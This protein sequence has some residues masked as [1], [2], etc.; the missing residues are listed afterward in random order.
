MN[1]LIIF[2]LFFVSNI[3]CAPK[4]DKQKQVVRDDGQS[5]QNPMG[6]QQGYVFQQD[7]QQQYY[8][9]Q[10]MPEDYQSYYPQQYTQA[11]SDQFQG[12]PIQNQFGTNSTI[13]DFSTYQPQPPI[14]EPTKVSGTKGLNL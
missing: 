13:F 1:I 6:Y 12:I 3:Q 4:K 2:L 10:Q 7:Y 14:Q 11:F 5:S 8:Y 9:P